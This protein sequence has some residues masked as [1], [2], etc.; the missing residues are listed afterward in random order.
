MNSLFDLN[1]H[2]TESLGKQYFYE[3]VID[4]LHTSCISDRSFAVE[5]FNKGALRP[6]FFYGKRGKQSHYTKSHFRQ[7]NAALKFVS[8]ITPITPISNMT[9]QAILMVT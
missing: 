6:K 9:F 3:Q 2:F 7:K 5:G 1:V 8:I 4:F